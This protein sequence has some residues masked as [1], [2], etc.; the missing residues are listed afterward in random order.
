MWV[1]VETYGSH[2]EARVDF[3]GKKTR[4]SHGLE[5]PVFP[6][7]EKRAGNSTAHKLS[8]SRFPDSQV[9]LATERKDQVFY[10]KYC[11]TAGHPFSDSKTVCSSET[12]WAI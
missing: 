4:E 11:C 12:T 5:R 7:H 8:I 2:G 3:E 9:T 10:V 1:F 6:Y